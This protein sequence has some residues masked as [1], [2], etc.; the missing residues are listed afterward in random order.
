VHLG[1][2]GGFGGEEGV[3]EVVCEVHLCLIS[4]ACIVFTAVPLTCVAV[5]IPYSIPVPVKSLSRPRGAVDSGPAAL[6]SAAA[7]VVALTCGLRV[8][9]GF[10]WLCEVRLCGPCAFVRPRVPCVSRLPR[11]LFTGKKTAV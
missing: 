2:G 8:V 1:G 5:Y 10:G 7:S 11:C 4:L 3:C 6:E 9:G